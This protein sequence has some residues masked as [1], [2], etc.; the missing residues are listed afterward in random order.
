MLAADNTAI[1]GNWATAE[2][3]GNVSGQASPIAAQ[4]KAVTP[5]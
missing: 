5:I 2:A 3:T 1:G 4:V